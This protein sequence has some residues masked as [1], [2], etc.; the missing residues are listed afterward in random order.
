MKET[1]AQRR[2]REYNER[3]ER[4]SKQL[5]VIWIPAWVVFCLLCAWFGSLIR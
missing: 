1:K 5:F 4:E 3:L 2:H